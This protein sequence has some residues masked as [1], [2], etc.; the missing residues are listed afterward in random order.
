[1]KDVDRELKVSIT[2]ALHEIERTGDIV[3]V[4][5]CLEGAAQT[6]ADKAKEV[7]IG[8]LLSHEELVFFRLLVAEAAHNDKM[9]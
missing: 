2:Q 5:P 9:F 4:S 8:E 3:L 7:Y 6:I 1:M